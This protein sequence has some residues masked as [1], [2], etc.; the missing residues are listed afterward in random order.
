MKLRFL[1]PGSFL[2]LVLFGFA[3]VL[4]PLALAFTSAVGSLGE[5]AKQTR[6]ALYRTTGAAENSRTLWE[7]ALGMERKARLFGVLGELSA[8]T[9]FFE[10]YAE[11]E[12]ALGALRRLPLD[13][14]AR[15]DLDALEGAGKRIA[16]VLERAAD[17]PELVAS[18]VP[19]FPAMHGLTKR[20]LDQSSTLTLKEAE[21]LGTRLERAR[22]LLTWLARAAVPCAIL[23]AVALAFLISRPVAR[24]D[25]AIHRLGAGDFSTGISVGGPKDL[26]ELGNRLDWLRCRLV[27]LEGEKRKLLAHVSHDL[28]TPLTAIR[29]GTELLLE[30][31]VGP[32]TPE[33][34]EV[35]QIMHQNSIELQRL[36][37]NLLDL[38]T[39]SARPASLPAPEGLET[40]ALRDLVEEVLADHKPALLKKEI[41]MESRLEEVGVF[42]RAVQLRTV[43]DNLLGN[44]VKFTPPGGTVGVAI[45]RIATGASI[46][47]WDSG[48]GVQ[49]GE[50]AR[51]FEPFFQGS[52]HGSGPVKGSGLGLSIAHEHVK[53]HGGK[54]ELLESTV[55][56]RFR[57]TLPRVRNGAE[58]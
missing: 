31:V 52:L 8:R 51:I 7:R 18:V 36:I 34:Q 50:Q 30:G 23:L 22:M 12:E 10:H 5:L 44:A 55:G 16:D 45:A 26:Q 57:V 15:R 1:Q 37:E 27:E 40:V 53:A 19:E 28:K 21:L 49:P 2:S 11:F 48:P 39:A 43:F 41:R 58:T 25:R 13:E 35:A 9:A 47:V 4:L 38:S 54:L 56:A 24:I 33:Q 20:L 3:L 32:L 17:T 29:E 14:A 6:E 42:G 46:E